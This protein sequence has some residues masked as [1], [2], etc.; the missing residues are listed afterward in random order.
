MWWLQ[1]R[2]VRIGE[3]SLRGAAAAQTQGP[4]RESKRDNK[5]QTRSSGLQ[6]VPCGELAC[7]ITVREIDGRRARFAPSTNK[8]PS[9]SGPGAFLPDRG[10]VGRFPP[11][12]RQSL[13]ISYTPALPA[14]A[15]NI[16]QPLEPDETPDRDDCPPGPG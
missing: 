8:A 14:K 9:P 1:R 2:G 3:C 15:N 4:D 10:Y 6:V 5:Q 7:A 11:P 16:V 12:L 13:D